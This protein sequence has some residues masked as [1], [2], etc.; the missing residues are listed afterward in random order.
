MENSKNNNFVISLMLTTIG[1][2]LTTIKV[3][4]YLDIAVLSVAVVI[5]VL[6]CTKDK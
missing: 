2:A 3:D 1:T 5:G 4:Y 6:G